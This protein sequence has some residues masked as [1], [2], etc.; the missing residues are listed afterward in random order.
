M[1]N[2]LVIITSVTLLICLQVGCSTRQLELTEV[3]AQQTP[4]STPLPNIYVDEHGYSIKKDGWISGNI[5][6]GK[7]SATRKDIWK[8]VDRNDVQTTFT[9]YELISPLIIETPF[10]YDEQNAKYAPAKATWVTVIT[11]AKSKPVCYQFLLHKGEPVITPDNSW[12][13]HGIV[14]RYC[15][16]DGDGIFETNPHEEFLIPAWATQTKN[17]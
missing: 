8:D 13:D 6:L 16:L 7:K 2:F 15:D 9:N 1:N 14:V 10:A 17:K 11:V 5:R 3:G 12:H 4:Q